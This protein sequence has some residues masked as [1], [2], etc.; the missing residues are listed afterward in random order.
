M[1]IAKAAYPGDT[2]ME[3]DGLKVFIEE[4][5]Q[6]FLAATTIDFQDRRGFIL[7]G[8]MP[9]ESCSSSSCSC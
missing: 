2:A 3:E 7:T 6:S 8:G 4:R 1:D 5:A 9:Q